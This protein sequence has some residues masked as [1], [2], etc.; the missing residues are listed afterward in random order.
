M[1]VFL[2]VHSGGIGFTVQVQLLVELLKCNHC[3]VHR[4]QT[5]IY[6]FTT[7]MLPLILKASLRDL[8]DYMNQFLMKVTDGS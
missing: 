7:L 4:M 2:S 8:R 3:V 1:H 6:L 5:Q